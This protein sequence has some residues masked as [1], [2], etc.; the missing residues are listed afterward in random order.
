MLSNERSEGRAGRTGD[1]GGKIPDSDCGVLEVEAEEASAIGMTFVPFV[2]VEVVCMD[3]VSSKGLPGGWWGEEGGTAACGELGDTS[4]TLTAGETGRDDSGCEG[5]FS[6]GSGLLRTASAEA[7]ASDLFS[8]VV[9]GALRKRRRRYKIK[10]RTA[11]AT[12]KSP[13][14]IAPAR[15]PELMLLPLFP[16]ALVDELGRQVKV[17]H[18]VHDLRE[19]HLAMMDG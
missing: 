7:G 11:P 4:M 19:K 2:C 6:V 18:A 10:T 13:A 15:A 8:T 17:G 16:S 5:F 12:A 14:M 9:L 3:C 1:D